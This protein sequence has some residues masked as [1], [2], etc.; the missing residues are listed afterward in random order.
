MGEGVMGVGSGHGHPTLN[1]PNYLIAELNT[2]VAN[3]E[4]PQGGQLCPHAWYDQL[5]SAW[6]IIAMAVFIFLFY[7]LMVMVGL[8]QALTQGGM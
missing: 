2:F 6:V 3:D 8:G 4:Q 5:S 1:V 7:S